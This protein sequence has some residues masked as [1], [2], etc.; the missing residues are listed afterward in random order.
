M[1]DLIDVYVYSPRLVNDYLRFDETT[2][3]IHDKV[4]DSYN[5][6]YD[7]E[8]LERAFKKEKENDK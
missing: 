7:T 5:R 3:Y 1:I 6:I 8:T 4:S 2:W